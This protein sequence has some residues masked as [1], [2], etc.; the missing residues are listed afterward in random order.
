MARKELSLEEK[1][2]AIKKLEK[3]ATNSYSTDVIQ[4][5]F[6]SLILNTITYGGFEKG[7]VYQIC[8]DSRCPER[9]F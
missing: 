2:N 6:K 4:Y 1:L 3:D 7:K 8:S 5:P 9:P